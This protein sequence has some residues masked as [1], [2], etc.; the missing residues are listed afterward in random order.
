MCQN[1]RGSLKVL[2]ELLIFPSCLRAPAGGENRGSPT[3][4]HLSLYRWAPGDGRDKVT[5]QEEQG[6]KF[7]ICCHV[8]LAPKMLPKKMVSR[9]STCFASWRSPDIPRVPVKLEEWMLVGRMS[10][11]SGPAPPAP[12]FSLFL[13][14]EMCCVVGAVCAGQG[15]PRWV[16]CL[17]TPEDLSPCPS[18]LL[19]PLEPA[20]CSSTSPAE[21]NWDAFGYG[22]RLAVVAQM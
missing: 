19:S 4:L 9:S 16:S 6:M 17:G 12:N 18:G 14:R 5:L 13:I 3:L 7:S 8:C 10:S 2:G 11:G 20:R 21:E 1:I 22:E 15:W